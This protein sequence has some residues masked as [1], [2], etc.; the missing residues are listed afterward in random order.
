MQPI[1]IAIVGQSNSANGGAIVGQSNSANSG[2][3]VGQS[4][5]AN[6]GAIV[7]QSNSAN[8]G[9]I[10]GQSNSANS[11]AI[12][13]LLNTHFLFELCRFSE[14]L[15][16]TSIAGEYEKQM[17]GLFENYPEVPY[18]DSSMSV[19]SLLVDWLLFYDVTNHY[20]MTHQAFSLMKFFPFVFTATHFLCAVNR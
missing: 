11:G 16:M 12:T 13:R 15:G 6:G 7:G 3:I 20:M 9:A 10:V 19:P 18:R 5:S 4:N 1:A 2:A 17:S 8:S 14:V